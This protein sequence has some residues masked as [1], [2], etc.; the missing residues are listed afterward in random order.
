MA[1]KVDK[2]TGKDKKEMVFS[3]RK[4]QPRQLV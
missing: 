1:G 2:E 4:P 3:P